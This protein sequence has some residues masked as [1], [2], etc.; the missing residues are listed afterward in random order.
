VWAGEPVTPEDVEGPYV[1]GSA[2]NV[3]R[4]GHLWFSAQPDAVG[5]A[6]AR[7]AGVEVVIDLRDPSE[8]GWDEALVVEG[9]GL[10]YHSVPVS[11]AAF[12][13]EALA[14]IQ[15]LVEENAEEQ[16]LIHCSSANR[17]GGWLAVSLVE[18]RGMT[19]EDALAVGRRVG[20]TKPVIEKSVHVYL[21]GQRARQALAP[22]KQG[23]MTALKGAMAESP[24]A[25]VQTCRLAAPSITE[26]AQGE[27]VAVGRTSHRTRNPANDPEPW[28]QPLLDEYLETP[29]QPRPPRVVE[30]G[31]RGT[32]YVEPIYLQE[33]CATCHGDAVDPE[34]LGLIR[35]R[36]PEDRAV[37]FA[38]GELRG[39]FWVVMAPGS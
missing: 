5:L 25:A 35:E 2:K 15:S 14:R 23:L 37:G 22:L 28:M 4:L 31:E 29:T 27:T 32:G 3:T 36:Y 7:D 16:I 18:N 30:L 39:L 6:A 9:L 17:V 13:P 20:I 19:E 26:G 8:R 11:G 12:D 21:A 10:V 24:Q 1:W 34:L 38:P 33:M